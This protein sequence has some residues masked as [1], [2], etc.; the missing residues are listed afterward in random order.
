MLPSLVAVS[1]A[2]SSS[3]GPAMLLAPIVP[4]PSEIQ[5]QR[6]CPEGA[7][8]LLFSDCFA[9]LIHGFTGAFSSVGESIS[10]RVRRERVVGG[11][12]HSD[13][14]NAALTRPP[15]PGVS[16]ARRRQA[17]RSAAPIA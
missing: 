11:R 15:S 2:R 3:V 7:R 5:T 4:A 9:Y 8:R 10:S 1:R 14:I 13:G 17:P 16:G 12:R 6:L